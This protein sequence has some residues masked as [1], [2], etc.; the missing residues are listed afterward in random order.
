M[1]K[2]IRLTKPL[3]VHNQPVLPLTTYD[4][5]ILPNGNRWNGVIGAETVAGV[6]SDSKGNVTLTHETFSAV[7]LAD[8]HELDR[9]E[10][11]MRR[12]LLF[13]KS[14]TD[15]VAGNKI[16]LLH[17]IRKFE[18]I[19]GHIN[20]KGIFSSSIY[21]SPDTNC[22]M[23]NINASYSVSETEWWYINVVL[24]VPY[25]GKTATIKTA[26]RYKRFRND[27]DTP[28]YEVKDST[29]KLGPL[30]GITYE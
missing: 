5:I 3:L 24:S 6:T 4:Q 14:N 8:E 27:M 21:D 9:G 2:T 25:G 29:V 18:S 1:A 10:G 16:N 13:A 7:P 30:Y 12:T 22:T 26:Y 15:Y 23:A 11:T 19:I 17:D 20:N 28:N